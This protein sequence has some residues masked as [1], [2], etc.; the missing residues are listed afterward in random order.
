MS[1]ISDFDRIK[2]FDTLKEMR[3]T[4]ICGEQEF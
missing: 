2:N 1:N 3:Q 4:G